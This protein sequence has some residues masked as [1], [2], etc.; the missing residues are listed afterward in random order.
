MPDPKQTVE[1]I[2]A[3]LHSP[4]GSVSAELIALA[5]D[6]A[7]MCREANLRLR[8]CVEFLFEGLRGEAVE[9]AITQPPV[10]EM[11]A[12]LDFRELPDW[13]R[14]CGTM[15]L[16]RPGR[17]AVEFARDL[18]EAFTK[19]QPLREPLAK[20]RYLALSRAPL[21][22]RLAVLRQLIALDPG[23][24]VWKREADELERARLATIRNEAA[25]AMQAGDVAAI[26]KLLDEL[27]AGPWQTAIPAELKETL[28]RSSAALHQAT[29]LDGLRALLPRVREAYA[30]MSY[31]DCRQ[32]FAQWGKIVKDAKLA[33]PSDLR[34][35][36]MPL[37]RWLDEQDDRRERERRCKSACAALMSAID[38]E[39][40]AEQLAA[41]YRKAIGFEIDIPAE[42]TTSYRRTLDTLRREQRREKRKQFALALVLVGA[43][44]MALGALAYV[45]FRSAVR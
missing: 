21:P 2:R 14:M 11:V 5:A 22:E 41:L 44:V 9:Y 27:Q 29:A 1:A 16:P 15:G 25:P 32:V 3:F 39:A 26:D 42:L 43:I 33:V 10:L 13:E 45:I 7:E 12:A 38:A 8:R 17:L 6:Y 24:P 20:L 35:E 34:Q 28:A 31:D 23:C 36:I 37:A 30:A 18:Q 4:R 40:P 19:Q